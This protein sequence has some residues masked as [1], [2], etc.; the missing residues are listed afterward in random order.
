M[1]LR[2]ELL[3]IATRCLLGLGVALL[4]SALW[5]VAHGGGF[6]HS[7]ELGCYAIGGLSIVLGAA[8]GSPSRRDAASA[9]WMAK[10]ASRDTFEQNRRSPPDR[11][12]GPTV[13]FGLVG[14]IL[15]L[16]G[17]AVG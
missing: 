11:T 17:W 12:L 5:A 7:F 2:Y 10:W 3:R 9:D 16:I 6:R 4:L 1:S 13:V 15:I 14:V 8:G